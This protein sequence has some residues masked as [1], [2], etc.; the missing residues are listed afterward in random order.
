M[1]YIVRLHHL[2]SYIPAL[3]YWYGLLINQK[4]GCIYT[5]FWFKTLNLLHGRELYYSFH[6][7][8]GKLIDISIE[9]NHSFNQWFIFFIWN[10]LWTYLRSGYLLFCRW[11]EC[12]VSM[13]FGMPIAA[14]N[15][16]VVLHNWYDDT[17]IITV[18]KNPLRR[19]LLIS[20]KAYWGNS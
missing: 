4:Q 5:S 12:T 6:M 20:N 1:T 8:Y 9:K 3:L 14:K 11:Q 13:S 10:I 18:Q 16:M 19:H 7:G 2:L 17:M 15:L